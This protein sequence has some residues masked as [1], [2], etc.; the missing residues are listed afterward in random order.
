MGSDGNI[1]EP[2]MPDMWNQSINRGSLPPMWKGAGIT[3][4]VLQ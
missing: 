1:S 2:Q 3:M 4:P